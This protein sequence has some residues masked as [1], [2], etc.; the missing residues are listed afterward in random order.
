M[1]EEC[2]LP[3][4]RMITVSKSGESEIGKENGTNVYKPKHSTKFETTGH[5]THSVHGRPPV[6]C[7][8]LLA[9]L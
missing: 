4:R 8:R 2:C 7:P 1:E 5:E 3:M 6:T 9:P